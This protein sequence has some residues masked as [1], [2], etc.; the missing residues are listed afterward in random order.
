MICA[1]VRPR[2]VAGSQS[3]HDGACKVGIL[4]GVRPG[5]GLSSSLKRTFSRGGLSGDVLRPDVLNG[6]SLLIAS[7][8]SKSW[9]SRP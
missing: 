3:A 4:I 1:A 2:G 9:N 7:S 5:L 6:D 8:S